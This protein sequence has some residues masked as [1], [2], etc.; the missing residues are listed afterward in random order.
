MNSVKCDV[1]F[2]HICSHINVYVY[3]RRKHISAY[4]NAHKHAYKSVYSI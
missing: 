2:F 3:I 4:T 1:I